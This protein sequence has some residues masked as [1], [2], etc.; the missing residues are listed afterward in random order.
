MI[1]APSINHLFFQDV[2]PD[3]TPGCSF[4]IDANCPSTVRDFRLYVDKEF[5]GAGYGFMATTFLKA[6]LFPWVSDYHGHAS[7]FLLPLGGARGT[8]RVCLLPTTSQAM[9]FY[10]RNGFE[11]GVTS[12]T[13][14]FEPEYEPPYSSRAELER[15]FN[16]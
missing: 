8:K 13:F 1:G 10:R 7:G 4:V 14:V 6:Y 15:F 9:K 11:R 3:A 12:Q 16:P 5:R 2:I